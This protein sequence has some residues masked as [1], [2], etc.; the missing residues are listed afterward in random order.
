MQYNK[1]AAFRQPFAKSD[2]FRD[3]QCQLKYALDARLKVGTGYLAAFKR[4]FQLLRLAVAHLDVIAGEN[5][6][7]WLL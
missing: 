5:L 6:V 2:L 7:R 4:R 1:K 3:S